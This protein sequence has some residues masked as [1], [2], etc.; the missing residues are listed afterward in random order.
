[1]KESI[2]RGFLNRLLQHL[3][4]F[5]PGSQ[6]LRVAL[7]RARGVRIGE[8]V[9]IGYD[10]ILDTSYPH[11]I[12]IEDRCL[13]GIRATVLAHFKEDQ[14]V[15]IER[16][17]FIGPGAIILPNVVIGHG[18]VVTAGSVVTTSVP[19]LTVVRGNPAIPVAKCGIPLRP[20]V[21][22]KEFSKNLK[23]FPS[24]KPVP[25]GIAKVGAGS[26]SQE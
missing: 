11:L 2:L 5:L 10:V 14:G 20:E 12:T 19:P 8:D 17:A 4:R 6:T 9:W 24:P 15:K 1:M 23:P 16:D 21:T 26:K 18:A 22:M 13:I 7:H 3:A 25:D